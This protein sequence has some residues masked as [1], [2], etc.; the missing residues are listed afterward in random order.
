[1]ASSRMLSVSRF[2][3]FQGLEGQL[4][5]RALGRRGHFKAKRPL[6]RGLFVDVAA[7]LILAPTPR[8][9]AFQVLLDLDLDPCPSRRDFKAYE[10]GCGGNRRPRFQ[11]WRSEFF[12]HAGGRDQVARFQGRR[13]LNLPSV[14]R[15]MRRV[16]C[17]TVQQIPPPRH[18]ELLDIILFQGKCAG[19]LR[20]V[21][22]VASGHRAISR[23]E[24]QIAL[25][26]AP[27]ST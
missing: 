8:R 7:R 9:R 18:S 4:A 23:R 26:R 14:S 2:L 25:L 6:L 13:Q 24:R 12:P 27:R 10:A 22:V 20:R 3:L 16:L 15:R 11:G 21:E 19:F 1:M 5:A 17:A